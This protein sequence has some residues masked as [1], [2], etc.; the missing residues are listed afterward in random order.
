M[1]LRAQTGDFVLL[2]QVLKQ[3]EKQHAVEFSY[4]ENEVNGLK[5]IPPNSKLP[6]NEKLT[7]LAQ[8]TQLT[9]NRINNKYIS[10]SDN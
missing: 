8:Q 10:I 1:S 3:I 7:N 5:V 4:V 9:F 6:L 2:V